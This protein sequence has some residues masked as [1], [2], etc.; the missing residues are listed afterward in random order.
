MKGT[1]NLLESL[2]KHNV[3][4]L[5][6]TSSNTPFLPRGNFLRLKFGWIGKKRRETVKIGESLF[7]GETEGD[8][9]R[10]GGDNW[11]VRT[12]REAERLVREAD[13]PER[14]RGGLRTT[15]LRPG[16]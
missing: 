14:E 13:D 15:V 1:S 4:Y 3:P 5:I 7:E 12:K 10:E 2:R 8:A 6:Y 11:Y 9:E 16:R